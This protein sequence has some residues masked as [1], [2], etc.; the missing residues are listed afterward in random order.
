MR[1]HSSIAAAL[2][3]VLLAGAGPACSVERFDQNTVGTMAREP[4]ANPLGRSD[5]FDDQGGDRNLVPGVVWQGA[6]SAAASQ[7]AL[8]RAL[9]ERGR[10]SF[11]IHCT[12]C[13]GLT[14][15]GTG[16]VVQRGYPK[17]PSYHSDRLRRAPD[18]H[19][20]Q[21]IMEGLGKMPPYRARVRHDEDRWAII[22]YVRAL[23][24]SQ[25]GAVDQVPPEQ[26]RELERPPREGGR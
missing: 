15:H 6:S 17:P 24:I 18:A 7:P 21:V 16:M 3:L 2:L 20:H 5:F 13:H 19:L 10:E 4:R 22:A 1:A 23:Q 9:L 14:G 11:A 8:S 12:P 26:R 25:H